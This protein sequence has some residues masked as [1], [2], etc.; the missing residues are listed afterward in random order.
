VQTWRAREVRTGTRR[1]SS[2][3]SL[4]RRRPT[5][6]QLADAGARTRGGEHRKKPE[7]TPAQASAG[8]VRMDAWWRGCVAGAGACVRRRHRAM[9]K[10]DGRARAEL[11]LEF[12]RLAW[13][14]WRPSSA[15]LHITRLL[16][17]SV[18]R[19][20]KAH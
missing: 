7:V 12:D 1:G 20:R 4:G 19:Q 2:G 9:Q 6:A 17:S 8:R 18:A 10:E 16:L 5:A 3:H 14:A 13:S 15:T 11:G